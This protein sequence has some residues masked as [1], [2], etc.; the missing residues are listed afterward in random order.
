[1]DVKT[2]REPGVRGSLEQP[3][4]YLLP[5]ALFLLMLAVVGRLPI[6]PNIAG[7]LWF[8]VFIPVCLVCWPKQF[9]IVPRNWVGSIGIGLLVFA[10]WIA[11]DVLIREYRNLPLFSN[12]ILGQ[13]HSSLPPESLHSPWVLSWRTARA[14]LIVPVVEELFW[15]AWLMRW[16][17]NPDIAHVRLGTYAPLAFWFTAVLFA[18]EHGPYW[19]VGLVAGVI[20]NWWMVRTKSLADCVLMHAITNAVLSGYVIATGNWQ[21]WQ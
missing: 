13:V 1:M 11:P 19:D 17:I 21:Y 2:L 9:S 8:V 10:I 5:F 12:G 6:K 16:L 15:R 20:Y 18:S 14:A 4:R 3:V 7:P